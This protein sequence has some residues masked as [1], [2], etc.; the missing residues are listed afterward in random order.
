MSAMSDLFEQQADR[1]LEREAPLA[2]RMRPRTL[3]E[4]LGQGEVVGEGRVLRKAIEQDRLF[5]M[6][7]WGPPGSGKTTLASIIA[8]VT[9]AHF[10][11]LSAVTAGV[12]DLHQAARDARERLGMHR[13]RTILLIDEIHRFNK[14]QQDVVLPHVENGTLILI[15]ATTENPSFE[16]NAAL[17]SR[18]RVLRL[19]A[20]EDDDVRLIVQRA[21]SDR[22]R[23]LGGQGVDLAEE[24]LRYLVDV[25][26]GDARVALNIL[27]VAA[28]T[29]PAGPE[30]HKRLT[31]QRIEEA[32][33]HRAPAYDKS[34]DWHYDA[35][36]ALHKSIRDSDPDA[37][38]YWL[39]R[40]LIAGDDPLYIARRLIRTAV[41]D[42]G[43]ADPYA[44]M[45]TVAAQQ[46]VHFIGLPEGEL[47]LAHA[48][49]YLATAPK[50]NAVYTAYGKARTE[51]EQTGHEPVPLHLR[52]APT[53]LMKAMGFGQGYKYAHD[54]D[55][56]AVDQDHLPEALRSHRYYEPTDRGREQK[57]REWLAQMQEKREKTKRV[58]ERKEKG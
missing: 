47:A 49:V 14:S 8:Q 9:H 31:L 37:A 34:G 15:G 57:I 16:V 54:Y 40:M 45:L 43:L 25:A 46:A 48:T 42:I 22:A 27:E 19:K 33:Q 5:S 29:T 21:L 4:F 41:E 24:G 58:Q 10:I 3:D 53:R 38:L 26:G 55:G 51:A 17:L 44:L 35:I 32:V 23:G 20:L 11:P 56:A 39:A 6:I 2:A 12:K 13:Q 7:L 1:Q 18:C 52:N 36:S 28:M 50:S 30:G